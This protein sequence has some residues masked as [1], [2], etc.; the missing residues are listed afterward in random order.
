MA[1]CIA[2]LIPPLIAP[3]AAPFKTKEG[4]SCTIALIVPDAKP[5]I[6]PLTVLNVIS[7]KAFTKGFDPEGEKVGKDELTAAPT[8]IP[9]IPANDI[10]SP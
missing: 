10:F 7:D 8:T 4:S 9:G 5:V 6:A 3:P 1:L 2:V